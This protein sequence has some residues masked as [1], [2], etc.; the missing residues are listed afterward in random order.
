M[1]TSLPARDG[2]GVTA[3]HVGEVALGPP[4][5]F[6]KLFKGHLAVI[7]FPPGELLDTS[8]LGEY[9]CLGMSGVK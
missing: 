7:S 8:R 5:G 2:D 1:Q 3:Q 9:Y 4:L 6:S